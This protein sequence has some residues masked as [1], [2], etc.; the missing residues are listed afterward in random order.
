MGEQLEHLLGQVINDKIPGSMIASFR[1]I[2]RK[3]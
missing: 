1:I 3:G 2:E